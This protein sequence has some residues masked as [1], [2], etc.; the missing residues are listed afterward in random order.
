MDN[1][2]VCGVGPQ[3]S[4]SGGPPIA[5]PLS[6]PLVIFAFCLRDCAMAMKSEAEAEQTQPHRRRI[7]FRNSTLQY[8][9]TASFALALFLL[10]SSHRALHSPANNAAD[11]QQLLS[12]PLPRREAAKGGLPPVP[13]SVKRKLVD[14]DDGE[15]K[16]PAAREKIDLGKIERAAEAAPTP[17]FPLPSDAVLAGSA[18]SEIILQPT[19]GSHRPQQNAVFAFA[20]GYDLGV[21][22][23]FVES[24]QNTGYAGDVVF[25]VSH[26]EG[27]KPGVA[28]Y[29]QWHSQRDDNSLRVVSYALEW[30]CY[31]KSGARILPNNKEGRGS[32]TNHGF[33]DCKIDGLY[34]DGKDGAHSRAKDPRQARPVATARYELY[35]IWSR[36]YHENSS[37]LIVDARDA[38][39]QSNPFD[40]GPNPDLGHVNLPANQQRN[41]E[42]RLDLF[43]ENFDAVNIAK[44]Q[45]NSRWIK[46][47]YGQKALKKVSSKPVVCS[48][49]TMGSQH[50][51]EMYSI[52]M[53]A[54]FD[55]TKCQ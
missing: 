39:F 29:L 33:S 6:L 32:T 52:A 41:D 24:L 13:E 35:W 8:A 51:I 31:K 12:V 45:Y 50:A 10:V 20:E 30:E 47:A 28:D 46:T 1:R 11:K 43:E 9:L 2:L 19:F 36:Q 27:M 37:I 16:S 15:K 34:S 22:V 26:V 18:P 48:G 38:Y 54:Q 53:V 17:S 3:L 7:S 23:T 25:S 21:Y 55:K 42:C 14:G 44:S 40:F 49:S 5:Q 4:Q